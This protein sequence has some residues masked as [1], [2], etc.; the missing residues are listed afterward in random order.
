MNH[1]PNPRHR[2]HRKCQCV[3]CRRVRYTLMGLPEPSRL[4][5]EDELKAL[6]NVCHDYGT[7]HEGDM[8]N[9]ETLLQAQAECRLSTFIT[10]AW[11]AGEILIIGQDACYITFETFDVT[12]DPPE[13]DA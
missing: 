2:Y 9:L 4:L 7:L 8:P 13:V 5:S 1:T 11:G 6:L 12:F 3:L 10:D